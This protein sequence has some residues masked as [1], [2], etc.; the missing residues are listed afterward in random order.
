MNTSPL[1]LLTL[2]LGSADTLVRIIAEEKCRNPVDINEGREPPMME[3]CGEVF[4]CGGK[5]LPCRAKMYVEWYPK[6]VKD[7]IK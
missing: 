7:I 6:K 3:D 5:C 1:E 4:V 2:Q